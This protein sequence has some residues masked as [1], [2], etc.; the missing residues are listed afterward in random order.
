[1]LG[2]KLRR[3]LRASASRF[4]LMV[5]AIAVSLTVFGAVLMVR[6]TLGRETA[7]AYAATEPASATILLE[8]AVTPDRMAALVAEVR[9]RPDVLVA[10]ARTQFD[11][12]V[13]V[14]GRP[15]TEPLQV[16]AAAPDDPMRV[17][18]FDLNGRRPG[19][20]EILLTRESL[21]LLGVVVGDTLTIE[22]PGGTPTRVRV[23][24]TAYDPSLSPAPQ[25]QR[26][27][28]YLSTTGLLDQLKVQIGDTT[29][30]RDRDTIVAA[31]SDLG[32]WLRGSGISI[33]EIQ[34]PE[35]YAHPHQWQADAILGA[36]LAGAAVAL[37][38]AA[39]LAA[40]M[41][42]TLFTRQIPQI[43]I[44]KA[45]GARSVHIG[46]LYGAMTLLVALAATALAL[47]P[48][49]LLARLG[50]ASISDGLGIRPS[51]LTAPLWT[52]VV[53]VAAGLLLPLLIALPPL[54]KACRTTVRAAIDHHGGSTRPGR[55]AA[56]LTRLS[57]GNRVLLLALRNTLRRP[58][59][60]WLSIGLL[61][62]AGTVFV[63]GL[64]IRAGTAAIDEQAQR[65][66]TWDVEAQL[67]TP[68]APDRLDALAREVPGVTAVEAWTRARTS[69]ARPGKLP[70]TSTYPDQGHG[71]IAL[72]TGIRTATLLEGRWLAPHETGSVVLSQKTRDT[73]LPGARPGDTVALVVDGRTTTWRIVGITQEREGGVHATAEGLAAATGRPLRANQLRVTTAKH[74][75]ATRDRV[76][77]ALEDTLTGAGID[78]RIAASVSRV[79]A[80][81][82]GHLGPVI[83]I[84]L[85]VALPMGVV[86]AIG[87]ATTMS[88]NVLDRRREFGVMH[89]IG[90]RP[91]TVRRVVMAEGV[92]LG[93]TSCLFAILPTLALTKLLGA[94]F[95]SLFMNAPLPFRISLPATGIWLAVAVVGAVLATDTAATRAS[96]LT[97]REALAYL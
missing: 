35:P 42:N 4:V 25:E 62:S 73:N 85:A 65:Q 61:A 78:V 75:G 86:G 72:T 34:V 6:T 82:A 66:R 11:T 54:V 48:A 69:V 92:L 22:P 89:A 14:N 63:A 24:G 76:A 32:D 84:L 39:I 36:L 94:G 93:L 31:A 9:Q 7:G 37:L 10:A 87:L 53:L 21:D 57:L 2:L 28:A 97:V 33:R 55:A 1:M 45:I 47:V 80:I 60:F 90:A 52:Y 8:R 12:R 74:D 40:T 83:L 29:P 20:G 58:A 3:D 30:S 81:S 23:T 79:D 15:R 44:M 16:F 88:A 38:L 50:V 46:R 68:V 95:G 67:T 96:R 51:S 26:G 18:K 17:A 49:A 27:R 59:R 91:R 64:S 77:T 56:F 71:S 13:E 19:P 5:I 70:V 41:L 43:G